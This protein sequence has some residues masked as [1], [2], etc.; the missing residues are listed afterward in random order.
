MS[1][2]IYACC[3]GLFVFMALHSVTPADAFTPQRTLSALLAGVA[4][5]AAVLF[6]DLG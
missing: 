5:A 6:H 2:L 4:A 3:V 1:H